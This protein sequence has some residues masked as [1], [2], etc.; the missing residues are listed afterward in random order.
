MRCV[1]HN[2]P[3][4]R[5]AI[6]TPHLADLVVVDGRPTKNLGGQLEAMLFREPPP[7]PVLSE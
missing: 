2:V 3:A 4:V 1:G 6:A 5:R 7:R